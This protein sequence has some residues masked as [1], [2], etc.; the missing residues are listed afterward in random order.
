MGLCSNMRPLWCCGL[1]Y[2]QLLCMASLSGLS[3]KMPTKYIR[4]RYKKKS[5]SAYG[6]A[7]TALKKVNK[8]SSAIETKH[9]DLA[10]TGP[11][12]IDWNP[13]LASLNNVPQ[14]LA[15]TERVGD[16]I[17]MMGLRFRIFLD[18]NTVQ[19]A[20][21][22][23]IVMYD[24]ENDI[25][26][27]NAILEQSGIPNAINSPFDV[28]TRHK[29]TILHDKVYSASNGYKRLIPINLSMK[30]NKVSQFNAGT[31]VHTQG[32]LRFWIFSD[33][34]DLLV[35]K[36]QWYGYSRVFYQDM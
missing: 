8:L 5:K 12:N 29:Y 3:V 14:G 32:R 28:D 2:P 33:T 30:L 27:L 10:I 6:L 23:C 31:T 17:K 22:R 7:K 16:K 9:Y 36:P 34:S 11:V 4:K 13:Q 1:Y 25:D 18:L 21:F 26:S 15:D 20:L 35:T 24:K 19:E